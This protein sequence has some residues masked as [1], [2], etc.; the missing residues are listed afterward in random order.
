MSQTNN[1]GI[2]DVIPPEKVC[3]DKNC[4]FHGELSLR[5]RIF[6]GKVVSKKQNKTVVIKREY[7]FYVP[8]Y[9][10][11]ERRNSKYSAHLPECLEEEIQ[12]GDV[13]RAAECR[14]LSKSVSSVVFQKTSSK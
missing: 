3:K 12:V 1:I 10:R 11:Y 14:K 5:G 2:P 13:V 7:D 9:Q 8:K 6:A 4:P